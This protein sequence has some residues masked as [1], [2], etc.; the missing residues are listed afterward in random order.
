MLLL[1]VTDQYFAKYADL[2]KLTHRTKTLVWTGDLKYGPQPRL[3]SVSFLESLSQAGSATTARKLSRRSR[4]I[5][6]GHLHCSAYIMLNCLGSKRVWVATIICSL[7]SKIYFRVWV[8]TSC[9]TS[10]SS[11]TRAFSATPDNVP[12]QNYFSPRGAKSYFS[13]WQL[14][15]FVHTSSLTSSPTSSLTSPTS[16]PTSPPPPPPLPPPRRS[17]RGSA[18]MARRFNSGSMN[19][20]RSAQWVCDA[21]QLNATLHLPDLKFLFA[22]SHFWGEISCDARTCWNLQ[23]TYNWPILAAALSLMMPCWHAERNGA[24]SAPTIYYGAQM[25]ST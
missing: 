10:L 22:A 12:I 7:T 16:S 1:C 20:K 14:Y 9:P 4:I 8:T 21:L 11:V 25:T 18:I 13:R 6:S 15:K 19:L 2:I 17:D 24:G 5:L 23:L 3:H